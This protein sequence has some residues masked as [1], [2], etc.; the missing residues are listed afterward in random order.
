MQIS[1]KQQLADDNLILVNKDGELLR[2]TQKTD[3][4]TSLQIFSDATIVNNVN[5]NDAYVEGILIYVAVDEKKN[6]FMSTK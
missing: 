1:N 2:C 4:K 3:V 6:L 5:N